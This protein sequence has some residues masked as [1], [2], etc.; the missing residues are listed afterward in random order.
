MSNSNTQFI[1]M[2][3][4]SQIYKDYERAFSETTGLPLNLRPIEHWK[5]AHRGRKHESPFCAL[6]ARSNKS[7]AACLRIQQEISN[8]TSHET[9]SAICFAGL[10]ETSVPLRV[11]ENL[12]GFLQVGEVRFRAPD[13]GGFGKI[14]EQ[15]R[16]WG[17][18]VDLTEAEGAWR[19]TRTISKGQYDQIVRLLEIFA[20]HLALVANQLLIRQERAEPPAITRARQFIEAHYAEELPLQK[21][22][23]AVNMSSFYFCKVFRKVTGLTFT[24]YLSRVRVEKAKKLLL[25]PNARVSEIAF[26]SGFA[27]ITNFNRTFKHFVGHSPTDYRETLPSAA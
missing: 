18:S 25:N 21:V 10:C 27:S 5:L 12:V 8:P 17:S 15:L 26:D 20:Q 13:K 2:L 23:R 22:A 6:M 11:G 14:A 16:E 4:E 7:C 1:A 3:S 9:Q 19:R 24:D